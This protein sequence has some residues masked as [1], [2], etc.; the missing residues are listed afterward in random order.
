MEKA[1]LFY[2]IAL[3]TTLYCII[4]HTSKIPYMYKC[5]IKCRF[6]TYVHTST[7][8]RLIKV[9]AISALIC[10]FYNT[11]LNEKEILDEVEEV[12]SV[13]THN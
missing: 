11:I 8:R 4:Y 13:R 6:I 3:G 7:T 2:R 12:I 1:N 9:N 10:N 5:L